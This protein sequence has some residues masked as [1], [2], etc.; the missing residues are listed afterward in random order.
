MK[1]KNRIY[2]P[3]SMDLKL[4]I[5]NEIH[6]KPYSCHPIYQKMILALRKQFYW[7]NMK[8]DIVDYL[9]KYLECQQLKEE[10]QH[11]GDLL[12]HFPIP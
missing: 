9:S 8:I 12:H 2:I 5:F 4:I 3:N 11:L 6:K 10:H 1:F 7:L